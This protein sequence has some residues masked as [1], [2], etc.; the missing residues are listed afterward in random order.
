M[1]DVHL[2]PLGTGQ[3]GKALQMWAER[4]GHLAPAF[5][6][7]AAD[8]RRLETDTFD[9]EGPGWQPLAAS[10]LARKRAKGL[11]EKILEATGALR[12]SLTV[13]DAEGSIERDEGD[14]LFVGSNIPYGHWH[15]T[16]G[17]TP[18]RPPQRKAVQITEAD[19]VRWLLIV[20]RYLAAGQ[21]LT[22]GVGSVRV[23]AGPG[24]L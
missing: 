11:S 19:K 15:Q 5:K 20:A 12:E 4:A 3:L 7:V 16:G 21:V 23:Q 9:K 8:F 1:A 24:G 17:T 13:E 14:S 18:G 22:P 10:T 2:E 6:A